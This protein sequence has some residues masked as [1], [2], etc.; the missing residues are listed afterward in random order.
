M[1][2][3]VVVLTV[4][5]GPVAG[6]AGAYAAPLSTGVGSSGSPV[7][8]VDSVNVTVGEDTVDDR[9]ANVTNGSADFSLSADVSGECGQRCRVVVANLTNNGTATAHNVTSDTRITVDGDQIWQ[10]TNQL[11]NVSVNESVERTA[12]I[13]ISYVEA[14]KIAQNDGWIT[15]TTTVTW[16]DGNRTFTERRQVM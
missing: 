2:V 9:E 16:A 4:V 15:I 10:R 14:L 1:L 13:E 8:P 3:A 11:G 5:A 7:S 6:Y 12:R